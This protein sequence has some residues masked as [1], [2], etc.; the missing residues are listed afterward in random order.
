MTEEFEEVTILDKPAL[1]TPVRIDRNTIP[2]GYHLYEVR[3]DDDCQ[4]DAVQIARNIYVNHWG[5][6]I[7]RDEIEFGTDGFLDINPMDLNYSTGNCR[8]MRD[9]MEK[10]PAKEEV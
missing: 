7:T 10:Y 6:L 5:S 4:G 2:Q 8:S 1:F 3:H 9:F